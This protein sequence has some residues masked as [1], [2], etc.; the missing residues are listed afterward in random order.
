MWY[1][2]SMQDLE[3]NNLNYQLLSEV[4][5]VR[6]RDAFTRMY[7]DIS[8]KT[9]DYAYYYPDGKLIEHRPLPDDESIDHILRKRKHKI[10]GVGDD[11]CTISE[12]DDAYGFD[13]LERPHT[14]LRKNK[15]TH[16][17]LEGDYHFFKSNVFT[18]IIGVIVLSKQGKCDIEITDKY[19]Y[20]GFS[21]LTCHRFKIKDKQKFDDFLSELEEG[22]VVYK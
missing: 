12:N 19:I 2:D 20:V 14:V 7:C 3:G 11:Y 15:L 10:A 6:I 17:V 5:Y 16:W 13:F 18:S 22:N 4:S 9:K 1:I 8:N 21:S